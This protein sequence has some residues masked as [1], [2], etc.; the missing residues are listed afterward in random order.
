MPDEKL[1]ES[2]SV[3]VAITGVAGTG[4][5]NELPVQSETLLVETGGALERRDVK[6]FLGGRRKRA[7]ADWSERFANFI[8]KVWTETGERITLRNIDQ[9]ARYE[10][11]SRKHLGSSKQTKVAV[12]AYDRVLALAPGEFLLRLVVH[13]KRISPKITTTH[14]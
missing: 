10:S 8:E 6:V 11:T 13:Q 14:L 5:V 3:K 12:I 7:A 4:A 9:V 2:T 1:P